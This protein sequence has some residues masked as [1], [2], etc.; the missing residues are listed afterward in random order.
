M[1]TRKSAWFSG[2]DLAIV[3]LFVAAAPVPA[4]WVSFSD[5]TAT[6]LQLSSVPNDDAEEK[7]IEI[8][9]LNRDGRVD[10]VVARKAPNYSY[11]PRTHVLLLK[12]SGRFV[13]RTSQYAPHFLSTPT[14]ARDIVVADL[15]G[16]N[17]LDVVIA[18][19]FGQQPR[20]YWNLGRRADGTWAGLYDT[21][22]WSFP[23]L[24]LNSC[25]VAAGDV[26]RDGDLDLYF[27]NYVLPPLASVRDT[28]LINVGQGQFQDQTTTRLGSYANSYNGTHA[29]IR[30][31]NGDGAP[32]IVKESATEPI[33][34]W[35]KAGVFLL[36]NNGSGV[37]NTTPFQPLAVIG[38]QGFQC[39]YMFTIGRLNADLLPD[40]YVVDDA[41]DR[42]LLATGVGAGR[43]SYSYANP[44]PS[45]RTVD[46]G[47][48]V[49]MADIDNDGDLDVG[50][51]STD[52]EDT[53]PCDNVMPFALLRNFL[54]SLTD[55]YT[56][57][58]NVHMPAHDVAFLDVN[59]DGKLD[60]FMGVCHGY[61]VFIRN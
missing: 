58:K 60:I 43:V 30:D 37:F 48:N 61:K 14:D 31:M 52:F 44:T 33:F 49:H 51:A 3:L 20:F 57:P 2:F 4:Q 40:I 17:W 9:D 28:L 7:E 18:N 19:T 46:W 23:V 41:Q 1:C 16:D 53:A 50:V 29:E 59:G 11:G 22:Q 47:G 26:D 15:N 27:S 35:N 55:P 21:T 25:G 6:R 38:T 45:P 42:V 5:Q 12:E 34:P 39:P 24:A 8:G 10:M 32:D 56:S 36:Y 54:G 13:D